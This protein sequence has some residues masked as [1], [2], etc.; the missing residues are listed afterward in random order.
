MDKINININKIKFEG[1][2][3]YGLR[4]GKGREFNFDGELMYEG[5]LINNQ[6]LGGENEG[7]EENIEK[8]NSEYYIKFEGE[9]LNGGKRI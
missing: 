5:Y 4:N 6:R 2:Y 3:L 9:Y 7:N 8:T 1:E